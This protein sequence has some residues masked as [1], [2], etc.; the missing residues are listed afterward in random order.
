MATIRT[1]IQIHDG[2]SPAFRSMN[3]AMNI[4]LNSFEA[5]QTASHNAVDTASIQAARQELA[6]AEVAF[7]EVEQ[8]I[9]QADQAQQRLNNDVRSGIGAAD[10]LTSKFKGLAISIGAAF[11][12]NKIIDI[13]DTMTQT[14]ARLNLMNDGLQTTA[15]LQDMIMQS[16]QRSRSSYSDT[17]DIISKLGQRAGDAFSNN[18]E[19]ISFAETLNK[20]F[21][22]AGAS[23]QEMTSASLQLTQAL[24]SGVLRGEELNAV[25]EAAPNVIQ[26]IADYLDV[27]IGAIRNMASEGQITAGIVKNAMLS[28]TDEVNKQFKNMPMTFGQVGTI[29]G[30]TLIQTFEPLIQVVGRGAQLIY[31]NWSTLEP[32][33]WGLAA[34]VGA[35]ALMTGIQTA[36]TWL[37]V[38]ANRALI[39]TLISNPLLWIAVLIGVVI[40][41]IY[42]WVQSVGGIQIAWQIA[43]NAILT[44]WDGI[45]I[46]FMTGT[47]AVQTFVGNMKVGV[48]TGL[49]DMTNGA[50]DIINGFINKVNKIPGVAFDTISYVTFGTTA[51]IENA[52]AISAREANIAAMKFDARNATAQRQSAIYSAQASKE[53]Q[54]SDLSALFSNDQVLSNI[55]D[56]SS[57][58]GSMAD[59]MDASEEELKY[60]RD[61]AEQDVINRFTTAEIS[62]DMGGIVNHVSQNTDLDG[63]VTYLEETLYATLES[64]A[65]GVH[66]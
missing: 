50:V 45:Q 26:S 43:A 33:F 12:V 53:A 58:T 32:I 11:G 1:A 10:G 14:T 54:S 63:V 34:G 38:A 49:Q 65:E 46:R 56:I 7:D 44:A 13:S 57:N 47:N 52:A 2:M 66:E 36:A 60:L 42:K 51:A 18:Q 22:I 19:T 41:A 31:D 35:F 55:A 25:F 8:E 21:V 29:I 9:R 40:G 48:L 37:Q 27:P 4:V 39:V 20:M 16:A 30:N 24:G 6:R 5:I 17:A 3:N 59:S 61:L 23:Q 62:V 64:V 28:A 15:Q